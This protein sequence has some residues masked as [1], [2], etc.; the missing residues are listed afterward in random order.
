VAD[1]GEQCVP[2]SGTP[3]GKAWDINGGALV[4]ISRVEH[5]LAGESPTVELALKS[6]IIAFVRAR[7][8][9]N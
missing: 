5:G 3:A 8:E 9:S 7:P 6:S 2:Q 1:I 4:S